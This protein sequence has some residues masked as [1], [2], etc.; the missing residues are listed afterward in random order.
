M[1]K[2][3]TYI[4]FWLSTGLTKKHNTYKNIIHTYFFGVQLAYRSARKVVLIYI[5]IIHTYKE[6]EKI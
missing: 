3:N 4:F 1:K 2:Y 6:N 5:Y